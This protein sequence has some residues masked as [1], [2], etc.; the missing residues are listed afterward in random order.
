MKLKL[1]LLIQDGLCLNGGG[2]CRAFGHGERGGGH[3]GRVAAR[4]KGKNRDRGKKG[5]AA[6][7]AH[8]HTLPCV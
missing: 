2:Y 5:E 4:L 1:T 8:M 6:G 7:A 3:R